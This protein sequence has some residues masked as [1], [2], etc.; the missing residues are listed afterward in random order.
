VTYTMLTEDE[1]LARLRKAIDA[2]KARLQDQRYA[3]AQKE[4]AKLV[5]YFM[6]R[7][8][9][10]G[11]A[12][13]RVKTIPMALDI[14]LRVICDDFVRLYWVVQ[15]EKNAAAYAKRTVSE[16]AK[17]MRLSLEGG[18]ARVRN[19][20]TG[21]D[22]T[23]A[24]LKVV[25]SF[26]SPSRSTEQMAKDCGLEKIYLIPFRGS[27]FTVHGNTF[28]FPSPEG[29]NMVA[30]PAVIG[31]LKLVSAVADGYPDKLPSAKEVLTILSPRKATAA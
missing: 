22:A 23:A 25:P 21:Q 9:Q 16:M 20:K 2:L 24:L 27:S 28:K 26:T 15:S 1:Y 4:Q 10:L 14:L 13:C 19:T 6:D 8:V 30:F 3:Q 18:H 17:L 11:E 12:T 29:A 5:A 7:A 31:F